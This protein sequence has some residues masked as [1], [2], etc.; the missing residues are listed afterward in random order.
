MSINKINYLQYAGI[1]SDY[2]SIVNFWNDYSKK[3]KFVDNRQRQ[4]VILKYAFFTACRRETS[5][6]LSAIGSV[7]SKD[8]ATVLHAV[9]S[10][11]TNMKFSD[12]YVEVYSEIVDNLSVI[13]D[14][15]SEKTEIKSIND[16]KALRS[17]CIEVSSRLRMTILELKNTKESMNGVSNP[18]RVLDENTFLKKHNRE[19]YERNKRLEQELSRIKNL[20]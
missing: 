4:N 9:R 11:D 13:L 15:D 12:V 5:L 16:I 14:K 18:K 10:H 1:S 2:A 7:I 8:H 17:R 3:S 6:P 19:L 20:I